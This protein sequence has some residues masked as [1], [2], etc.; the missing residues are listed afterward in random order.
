MTPIAAS[1]GPFAPWVQW[2]QETCRG[3]RILVTAVNDRTGTALFLAPE[4][5]EAACQ[6]GLTDRPHAVEL[7]RGQFLAGASVPATGTA[8]RPAGAG[9]VW[10]SADRFVRRVHDLVLHRLFTRGVLVAQL[11]LAAVGAL[12]FVRVV[13]TRPTQLRAEPGQIPTI[14]AL[15]LLAVAIHELGHALVTVHHGRHVRMVGLRLH[16]G[17]PAFYVDS[18]DAL[19]LTRRQRLAQVAAGPWAEWLVNAAAA[20]VL[21]ALPSDAAAAAVLHRFVIVNAIGIALN[22]IPFVGL[23]GALLLGDLVKEPDLVVRARQALVAPRSMAR[24]ERWIIGYAVVNA[25]V[26]GLLVVTA[27]FFWWELFGGLV[28]GLCAHGPAGIAVLAAAGLAMTSGSVRRLVGRSPA[29]RRLTSRVRFRMER[30]WR[31]RAIKAFRVLPEVG[32]LDAAALGVLA[33]RLQRVG[34]GSRDVPAGD[35][36]LFVERTGTVVAV[37]PGGT[38]IAAAG[39]FLPSSV[40]AGVPPRPCRRP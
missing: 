4:D 26:A 35:G 8:R 16:L 19:L 38:A 30:R 21:L 3:G 17:S 5:I 36:H 10:T 28:A 40:V 27:A 25:A 11:L 1:T 34:A 23:D 14:F 20:L 13:T 18:V 12:A 2:R 6:F 24:R 37:S 32:R 33:G 22:L 39:V 9:L 15:G 29:A 7:R 31:V